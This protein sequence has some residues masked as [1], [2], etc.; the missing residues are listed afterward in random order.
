MLERVCKVGS[1]IPSQIQYPPVL[2]LLNDAFTSN[3]VAPHIKVLD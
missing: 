3:K 1:T 2:L